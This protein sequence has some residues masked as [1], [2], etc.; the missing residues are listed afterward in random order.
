MVI[1]YINLQDTGIAKLSATLIAGG[2]W[3]ADIKYNTTEKKSDIV[4]NIIPHH[5]KLQE[6]NP[7]GNSLPVND[8]YN[9]SGQCHI[10]N[11]LFFLT[12]TNGFV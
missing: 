3:F 9:Y 11:K 12:A 8:W 7:N 10:F 4:A 1:G 6:L 2:L 5:A